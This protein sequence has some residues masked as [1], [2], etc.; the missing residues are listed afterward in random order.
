[1]L[2]RR[3]PA[4]WCL[5]ST[6]SLVPST[7]STCRF[8]RAAP[9]ASPRPS[10]RRSG[11]AVP[12]QPDAQPT[13]V[14]QPPLGLLP[15]GLAAVHSP[16]EER[17]GLRAEQGRSRS[18]CSGTSTRSRAE[19]RAMSGPITYLVTARSA[20]H[21]PA[22]LHA[23]RLA[24]SPGASLGTARAAMSRCRCAV[25]CG[26]L[27]SVVPYVG[28]G[29]VSPRAAASAAPS[30]S[31]ASGTHSTRQSTAASLIVSRLCP[32]STAATV[33]R[34]H[35]AA[36]ARS[37]CRHPRPVLRVRTLSAMTASRL[38]VDL[39]AAGTTSS[40]PVHRPGSTAP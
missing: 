24:R 5:R 4:A 39:S 6:R 3:A 17:H 15:R 38:V 36:T 26:W 16:V 29:E 12:E 40:T 13:H 34:D 27:W 32:D 1:M 19:R 9:G 33:A 25:A 20:A 31:A 14:V 23:S 21:A 8:R 35:P 2:R 22:D 7:G 10:T 18:R 37:S 30:S 11:D 28:G